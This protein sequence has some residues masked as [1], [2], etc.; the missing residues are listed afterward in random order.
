MS[1][2]DLNDSPLLVAALTY[3]SWGW[4]VLP[5]KPSQK[6][7]ATEH[8]LLEATKDLTII[9]R[10][11]ELNPNFNIGLVTGIAFDALDLDGQE[12]IRAVN[13]LSGGYKHA[14]PVQN[15][16]RGYHLIFAPSGSH[17]HAKLADAPL[18]YRGIRGYIVGA[19]SIH[20]DGHRYQWVKDGPLPTVPEFLRSLLFPE[21]KVRRTPV[22]D[23][24]IRKALDEEKDIVGIFRELGL[25]PKPWGKKAYLTCPFHKGD[26][27]PSLVLYLETNSFYCF[28]CDEYGD[29]LNVRRWIKTGKLR[30]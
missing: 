30:R 18:D 22:D 29:P 23:P 16:G 26:N 12:A 15:T 13:R 2:L 3:A 1:L 14:G 21:P 24:N 8:G 9:R 7:P 19:P 6:Q 4:P 17:N 28:G 11:W 5:L 27:T 10:W 20:P 25:D